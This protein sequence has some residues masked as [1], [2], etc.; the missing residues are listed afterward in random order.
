MSEPSPVILA[1]RS[2]KVK[3]KAKV[4]P[5]QKHID[6]A[7]KVRTATI[8]AGEPI[9]DPKHYNISLIQAMTYYNVYEDMK[10]KRKWVQ[11][12]LKGDLPKLKML[13]DLSDND[14]YQ[15]SSVIRLHQRDQPLE[16]KEL[17]YIEDKL[18]KLF[19]EYQAKDVK[20]DEKKSPVYQKH[21]LSATEKI[22]K[23]ANTYI[24][25]IEGELDLFVINK[26]SDFDMK[27]YIE[28]HII[29][30]AVAKLIAGWLKKTE[31]E[32]TEAI[33]GKD[34]QLVESYA[35]FKPLQLKRYKAFVTGIIESSSQQVVKV[36]KPKRPP[37]VKPAS[38]VVKGIKYLV[39][40]PDLKL[41]SEH[42]TKLINSNEVW[43]YN[44]K[45]RRMTVLKASDKDILVV[46][47]STLLNFDTAK[48]ETKII[49]KPEEFLKSPILRK[50][51][52]LSMKAIK[53]KPIVANGRINKDTIIFA[54]F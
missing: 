47:G 30:P 37:K 13:G 14:L 10:N 21:V 29:T 23:I 17:K 7:D 44:T 25:E 11:T 42:P 31:A 12:Y 40:F 15:L 33:A 50:V 26:K 8:G 20:K 16:P 54:I 18:A 39:E 48:S 22:V 35:Y 2:T 3:A 1:K 51:L 49:R 28:K 27:A 52:G 4:G 36:I 53:T 5:T 41:K 38:E 46:K 24:G 19:S 45:T 6:K 34:E 32:L 43:L 9:I